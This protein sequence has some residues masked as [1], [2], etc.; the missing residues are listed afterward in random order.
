LSP[1]CGGTSQWSSIHRQDG[2]GGIGQGAQFVELVL[3]V[4]GDDADDDVGE[5]SV[6]VDAV[7]LRGFYE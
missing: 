5:V 2:V 7:K 4:A 3:R 1:E 6:Q